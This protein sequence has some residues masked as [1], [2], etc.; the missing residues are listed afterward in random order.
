[1][2]KFGGKLGRD[3]MREEQRK[4]KIMEEDCAFCNWMA[5]EHPQQYKE[6]RVE[7]IKAGKPRYK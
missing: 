2:R 1:M 3:Y 5:I 4:K 6:L 7:W